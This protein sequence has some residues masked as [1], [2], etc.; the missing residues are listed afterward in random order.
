MMMNMKKIYFI[1][2]AFVAMAAMV[3]CDEEYVTYNDAEYVM[4]AEEQSTNLV[5]AV[6]E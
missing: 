4:F 2:S 3:A 1:L 5:L 6:Q